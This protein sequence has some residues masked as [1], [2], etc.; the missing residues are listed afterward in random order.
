[1][2]A[3]PSTAHADIQPELAKPLLISELQNG[4]YTA[5]LHVARL[6]H[7]ADKL[8]ELCIAVRLVEALQALELAVSTFE[9]KHPEFS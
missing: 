4:L 9:V 8:H 2:S 5:R 3:N 6:K 7:D 1:M